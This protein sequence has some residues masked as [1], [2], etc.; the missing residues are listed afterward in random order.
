MVPEGALY[1]G[2]PRH[3]TAVSF[4][5]ELRRQVRDSFTEMHKLYQRR[6]TPKAKPSKAC[7]AC[8]LKDICLPKLTGRKSVADYLS[9][10]VEEME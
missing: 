4:T 1:Y 9:R 8:S 6:H 10:T 5:P 3:R 7:N 2:E